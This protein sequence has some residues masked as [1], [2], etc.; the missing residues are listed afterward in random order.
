MKAHADSSPKTSTCMCELNGAL[1]NG[2]T[3]QWRIQ[4]FPEGGCVNSQI[5]II[6]HIFCRKLHKNE[7]I[8][9]PPGRGRASLA[10]LSGPP[11]LAAV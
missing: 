2:Y 1:G 3:G 6:L 5:G 8:F 10:P 7:I 4:D 9:G 11:M